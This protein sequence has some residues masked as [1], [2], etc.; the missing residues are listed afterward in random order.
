[1]KGL[2]SPVHKRIIEGR[3]VVGYQEVRF[4]FI[5]KIQ[6]G[7]ENP[8]FFIGIF[9]QKL[10]YGY[11]VFSRR[12]EQCRHDDATGIPSVG[13]TGGFDIEDAGLE[14]TVVSPLQGTA[15]FRHFIFSA[16]FFQ[17]TPSFPV[18]EVL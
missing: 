6:S 17:N 7:L 14:R 13:E 9:R 8:V 4:L 15:Q 1:M 18:N 2:L 12:N 11:F 10:S 3:T 5:Q 16:K